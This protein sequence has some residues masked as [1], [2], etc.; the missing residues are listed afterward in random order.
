MYNLETILRHRFRFY[1]LLD[2]RLVGSDCEVECEINVLKF[3]SMEEIHLRFS[4][5]KLWLDDF[6]D[7]C[8]AFYKDSDVDTDW[9]D[10]L[11]NNPMMCPEEPLDH[12]IA[13]LLHTKFNT[14]GGDVVQI[15]RT[16]LLCDTSRGFSNAISGTTCEWLPDMKDWM[17]DNPM[18]EQPWWYRADVSTIDIPKLTDDL[19]EQVIDFGGPLIEILRADNDPNLAG[20]PEVERKPAEIIKPVFRPRIVN[21]DED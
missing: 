20:N 7:G 21:T 18:H 11:S 5:I 13:T 9:I 12:I 4:A 19:D 8:V 3:D 2:D 10:M 16:H 6:V 15:I 14:I 17:G 1:R